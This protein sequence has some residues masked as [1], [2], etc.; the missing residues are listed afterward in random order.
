MST[1]PLVE[2]FYARLWNAG[3]EAALQQLLSTEFLFRGS[4]GAEIKGQAAFWDYVCGVRTALAHY[5]CDIREC[6]F[7]GQRAFAKMRFSGTHVG[8]FRG[9]RPTG[10]AVHWEGAA[11]FRFE[12]ERICELWVLGDLVGLDAL[13]DANAQS[14]PVIL[15]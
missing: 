2:D 6:V 5:R 8:V 14:Q 15:A 13:L 7:E 10:L 3:D 1:P 4:L 11:L 9:H 12:A